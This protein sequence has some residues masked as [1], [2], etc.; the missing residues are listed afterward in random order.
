LNDKKCLTLQNIAFVC[1]KA[2]TFAHGC[3]WFEAALHHIVYNC[4][5]THS[6]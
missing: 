3:G 1:Y 5:Q 4:V 6:V 2:V